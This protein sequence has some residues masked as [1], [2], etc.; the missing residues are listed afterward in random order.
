M[1]HFSL[2]L[3]LNT[4]RLETVAPPRSVAFV[5]H[6]LAVKHVEENNKIRKLSEALSPKR[7]NGLLCRLVLRGSYFRL[8]AHF[9]FLSGRIAIVI[10]VTIYRVL[11]RQ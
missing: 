4:D 1:Y 6:I 10:C 3:V 2:K 11:W 7:L 8:Q 9:L 5:F